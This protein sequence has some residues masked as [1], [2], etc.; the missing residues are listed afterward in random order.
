VTTRT[1]LLVMLVEQTDEPTRTY[2]TTGDE[3]EET[4]RAKLKPTL[5]RCGKVIP[6]D[7]RKRAAGQR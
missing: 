2:D 7:Q 5:A 6:F 1:M 4:T 3:V